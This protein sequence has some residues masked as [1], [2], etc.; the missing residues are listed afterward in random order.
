ML[1]KILVRSGLSRLLWI[2]DAVSH[3]PNG[4]V[5][6]LV[7]AAMVLIWG[8]VEYH[9][10]TKPLSTRSLLPGRY[11]VASH[12]D[13]VA[14]ALDCR[15]PT[16]LEYRDFACLSTRSLLYCFVRFSI[17]MVDLGPRPRMETAESSDDSRDIALQ[18]WTHRMGFTFGAQ[19]YS[20]RNLK[21]SKGANANVCPGAYAP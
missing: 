1:S 4:C 18:L 5:L 14:F 11:S 21:V 6:E 7:W 19:L 15:S 3:R 10:T 8:R 13:R 2:K 20:T 12:Q 17:L 16:F 9:S